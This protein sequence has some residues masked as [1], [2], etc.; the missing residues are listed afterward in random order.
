MLMGNPSPS[1]GVS[2]AITLANQ[3]GTRFTPEGWKAELTYIA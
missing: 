3:A 1:Y 2:L